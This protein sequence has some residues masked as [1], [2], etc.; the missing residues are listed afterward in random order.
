LLALDRATI[1]AELPAGES[2]T[3]LRQFLKREFQD[4]NGDEKIDCDDF[5][6][7]HNIGGWACQGEKLPEDKWM[8]YGCG[9]KI[10][11]TIVNV[12]I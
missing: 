3:G 4:C 6:I 12:M 11:G 10:S 1:Y 7:I 8:K 2:R 9:I 5:L